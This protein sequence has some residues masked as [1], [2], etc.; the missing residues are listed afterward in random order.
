MHFFP[1]VNFF[2]D[3]VKHRIKSFARH[4]ARKTPKQHP[5]HGPHAARQGHHVAREQ[6]G[7]IIIKKDKNPLCPLLSHEI[8]LR[9]LNQFQLHSRKQSTQ[10]SI[11]FSCHF[12]T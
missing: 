9:I 8:F 4:V 10:F 2:S 6:H 7:N 12:Q 5:A 3:V 1:F 11:P